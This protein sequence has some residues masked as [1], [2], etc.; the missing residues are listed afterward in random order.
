MVEMVG[1]FNFIIYYIMEEKRKIFGYSTVIDDLFFVGRK[2]AIRFMEENFKALDSIR[3][4]DFITL[5]KTK[6]WTKKKVIKLLKNYEKVVAHKLWGWWVF[7]L[8]DN[9]RDLRYYVYI[10]A[11]NDIEVEVLWEVDENMW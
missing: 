8:L 1:V 10:G 9:K 7:S 5:W 4:V 2:E 3:V 11:K 6:P